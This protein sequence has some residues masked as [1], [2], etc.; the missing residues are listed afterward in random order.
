MK[1]SREYKYTNV[2]EAC[3]WEMKNLDIHFVAFDLH[4]C[5]NET[6]G[7]HCANFD[8]L[9]TVSDRPPFGA[10]Q[11]F[12]VYNVQL[13]ENAFSNFTFSAHKLSPEQVANYEI[14]KFV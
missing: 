7:S 13:S 6:F 11:H 8:L 12:S 1:V 5:I 2:R 9:R 3:T 10:L 4:I 14:N